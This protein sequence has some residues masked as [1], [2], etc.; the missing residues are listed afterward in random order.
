MAKIVSK[1]VEEIKEILSKTKFTSKD[2]VVLLHR[3]EY[4]KII[5]IAMVMEKLWEN[6]LSLE[7]CGTVNILGFRFLMENF[8]KE[9]FWSQSE[10]KIRN[11]FISYPPEKLIMEK[12][13]VVLEYKKLRILKDEGLLFEVDVTPK[14]RIRF[15][16][17]D[18]IKFAESILAG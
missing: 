12:L 11:I 8:E 18:L 9:D 10:D 3:E 15:P 14:E 16:Y 4:K 2:K 13:E 1:K 7:L 5:F 6:L 17:K